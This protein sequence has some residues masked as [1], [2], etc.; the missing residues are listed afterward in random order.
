MSRTVTRRTVLHGLG[1]TVVAV[2][3]T[4]LGACTGPTIEH[5]TVSIT[6]TAPDALEEGLPDEAVVEMQSLLFEADPFWRPEN[7]SMAPSEANLRA[8]RRAVVR[9]VRGTI[10]REANP[11]TYFHWANQDLASVDYRHLAVE[12]QLNAAFDDTPF[13]LTHALLDQMANANHFVIRPQTRNLVIFGLRGCVIEAREPEVRVREALPDHRNNRC[14]LGVWNPVAQSVTVFDG[15][16]VPLELH[17]AIYQQWYAANPRPAGRWR[18]NLM[19]Q[20][21]HEKKVGTMAIGSTDRTHAPGVLRQSSPTPVLREPNSQANAFTTSSTW[22]P[23]W[24]KTSG[25]PVPRIPLVGDHI[26]A[27][28]ALE[29]ACLKFSSQGCQTV[30]GY[31]WTPKRNLNQKKVSRDW[32]SFQRTLGIGGFKR[33]GGTWT[34]RQ[35]G[36]R[37]PFLLLSGREARLHA[38]NAPL[39]ALQRIRIGSSA[40]EDPNHVVRQLQKALGMTEASGLF[41]GETMLRLLDAQ[42][43]SSSLAPDGVVGPATAAQ[44]AIEL[45]A[46]IRFS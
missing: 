39:A 13:R 24:D 41:D 19:P 4:T 10:C 32:A 38:T 1:S 9:E 16:T 6:P 21:L 2:G 8:T 11:R 17:A 28:Y 44:L 43:R 7:L 33:A 3:G 22:D 12:P 29:E 31:C 18:T 36:E 5:S 20:G 37:F 23:P 30:R 34:S 45:N 40:D 35:D 26:H 15:S 14:V 27:S 25:V 42:R 46:P